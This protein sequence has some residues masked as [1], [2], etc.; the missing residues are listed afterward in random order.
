MTLNA[1]VNT[2]STH[3]ARRR[4]SVKHANSPS[5]ANTPNLAH[6]Q[7]CFIYTTVF[8]LP[9]KNG[10]ADEPHLHGITSGYDLDATSTK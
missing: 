3:D 1:Q 2:Q 6:F 9:Y 10:E 7:I 4:H 8:N 5:T